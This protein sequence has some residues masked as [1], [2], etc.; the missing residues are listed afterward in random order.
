MSENNRK[1]SVRNSIIL[2]AALLNAIIIKYAYTGKQELYWIL[3]L[4][5]PMLILALYP[6]RPR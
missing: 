3:L 4:T 2:I 1:I 5:I 6:L